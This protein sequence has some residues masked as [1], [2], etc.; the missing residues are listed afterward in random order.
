VVAANLEEAGEN[1]DVNGPLLAP[2]YGAQGGGGD[3]LRRL[4]KGVERRVLPS[5]SREVLAHGPD[6]GAL[7]TAAIKARDEVAAALG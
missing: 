1:L 6:P 7:R 4:F 5:T 2:G 3:D